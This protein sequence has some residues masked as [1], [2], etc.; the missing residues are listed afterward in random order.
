MKKATL[1]LLLALLILVSGCTSHDHSGESGAPSG[2]THSA[3]VEKPGPE[4][5]D[6]IKIASWKIRTLRNS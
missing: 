2:E 3:A 5:N 6:T 1:G 4:T